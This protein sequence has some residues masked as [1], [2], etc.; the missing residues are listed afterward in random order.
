MSNFSAALDGLVTRLNTISGMTAFNHPPDS[1][2]TFPACYFQ[3][4]DVDYLV[5][6]SGD[7]FEMPVD[8]VLLAAS[9]DD[10]RG[11]ALLY[12]HLDPTDSSSLIAAIKGDATLGGNVDDAVV[13]SA[14]NVGRRELGGG[15][16]FTATFRVNLVKTV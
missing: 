9:G 14:R 5:A 7:T 10:D 11:F 15:W 1:I 4:P 2:N 8:V 12:N 6:F 16:Y 13:E 3:I